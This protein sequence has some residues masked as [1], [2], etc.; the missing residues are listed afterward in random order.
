MIHDITL[1]KPEIDVAI[2]SWM[3]EKGYD[4]KTVTINV[5]KDDRTGSNS[6]TATCRVEQLPQRRDQLG[7]P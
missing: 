3:A 1:S 7:H 5:D 4:L 2:A 6:F